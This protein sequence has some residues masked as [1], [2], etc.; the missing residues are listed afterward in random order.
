MNDCEKIIL[1]R[2]VFFDRDGTLN[3]DIH[4]LHNPEDFEWMPGA[5]E[6]IRYANDC[7]FLAIVITN[8]SGVARGYYPES[9]VLRVYDWMNKELAKIGAHLDGIYYCPHH[10]QGVVQEYAIDCDCR[11]PKP[12][13]LLRAIEEHDIDPE[14]SV[15]IGDGD[16]DVACA[17]RAGVRGVK[18][19]GGSLLDVVKRA[20]G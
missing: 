5:R 20:I 11:K 2:A 17:E 9:D 8:Q 16:S 6:A 7:G 14:T 18:Y 3:V 12:G 1:Q 19:T 15:F 4:Y 10:P 13:L